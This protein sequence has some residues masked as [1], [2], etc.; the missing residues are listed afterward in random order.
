M[1]GGLSPFLPT[2]VG[3]LPHADPETAVRLVLSAFRDVPCWPQLP[4]RTFLE[5]MYIQ[6]AAGLPGA[7]IDGDKLFVE[8][9][10]KVLAEAESF[11]ERFLGED[12]SSFAIPAERAAG[13]HALLASGAGR[14]SAVKGQVTGPLSFGL[15]VTDRDKKPLFYDPVGRDILVKHLLRVAQWQVSALS[16]LSSEVIMVLDEPYLASVGSSLLSLGREEVVGCL[17]E[18]FDG[19]P[20]TRCGIHCCANTDWGLVLSSRTQY[21]SFDAYGF[22]D[23]LL[24]YPKEVKAFLDRGGKLAFGIVPTSPEG[25]R[26]ETPVT[27]ADRMDAIF[28]N[29]EARGIGRGDVVR[30]AV[31]TPACGLGTLPE[32]DAERAVMLTCELSRLLRRRFA[33]ITE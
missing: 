31:I 20:G 27:L 17:N 30:A 15:M 29:F 18:I 25:I 2:G 28:G 9:G 3:S 22:A 5:S 1:S 19:L 26:S 24:L 10:E 4:R 6:Y 12:A 11:Y 32:E 16:R 14:Y 23:S 33:G 21:L 13:L 8:V 7:V